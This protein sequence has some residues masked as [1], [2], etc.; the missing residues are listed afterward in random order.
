MNVAPVDWVKAYHDLAQ[1]QRAA[2]EESQKKA[3]TARAADSK[4]SLPLEKYAGRY[5]DAWYGDIAIAVEEGKLV[6]RF[7]HTPALTGDLEH[8]QYDTFKAR[9]RDRSL[10]ADAF[11]TFALKPD[12]SVRQV[13]MTPV[14]PLT[15]FS[16]DFED[17][18]LT[19]AK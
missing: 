8:W 15:D 9:W 17:L 16:F 13:N 19:P 6:M 18:L 5:T 10:A 12:G 11:V 7:S 4:P 2:A 1:H 14:S 3:A